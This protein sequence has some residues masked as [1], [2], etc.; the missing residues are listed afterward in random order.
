MCKE[1]EKKVRMCASCHLCASGL[2]L[3]VL[4]ACLCQHPGGQ[5][6]RSAL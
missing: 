4:A 5:W 3:L 1:E 6:G 2:G